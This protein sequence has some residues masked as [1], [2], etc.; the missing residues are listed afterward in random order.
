[1]AKTIQ[2][3]KLDEIYQ[4]WLTLATES[5]FRSELKALERENA[6]VEGREIQDDG[7]A[8]RAHE[9]LDAFLEEVSEAYDLIPKELDGLLD[10]FREREKREI[11]ERHERDREHTEKSSRSKR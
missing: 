5:A 1:M 10:E 4:R 8:E 9:A 2:P 7:K 11:H 3:E 6:R